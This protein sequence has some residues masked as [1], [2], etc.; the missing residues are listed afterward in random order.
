MDADHLFLFVPSKQLPGAGRT[1]SLSR[2]LVAEQCA[3]SIAVPDHHRGASPIVGKGA[4]AIA[5]HT[6]PPPIIVRPWPSAAAAFGAGV[7]DYSYSQNLTHSCMTD[8][9]VAYRRWSL[10]G[11]GSRLSNTHEGGSS[12][13]R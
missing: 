13:T 5:T 9:P 11:T 7:S 2:L 1:R 6:K 3:I 10:H 12:Y 4:T 8:T